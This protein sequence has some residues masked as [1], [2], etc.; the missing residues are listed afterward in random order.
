LAFPLEARRFRV[1]LA[2]PEW[3]G[4]APPRASHGGAPRPRWLALSSG[5][6]A[7]F[8]RD[9][10]MEGGEKTTRGDVAFQN[11]AERAASRELLSVVL[12]GAVC[13]RG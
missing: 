9:M 5:D 13:G 1:L 4:A 7:A 6:R 3:R 10:L 12:A 8:E 11:R 2:N